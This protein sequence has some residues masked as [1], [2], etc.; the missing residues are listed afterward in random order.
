MDYRTILRRF[1][2]LIALVAVFAL[3]IAGQAAVA[4]PAEEAGLNPAGDAY[5]LNMDAQGRLYVS[6][7]G[8]GEIVRVDSQTAAYTV[9]EE[10]QA[11]S[12][13]RADAA[14]KVWWADGDEGRFGR[15]DPGTGQA[16]WWPAAG[17]SGLL[18]TQVD[19]AGDFWAVA[20][21]DPL[22]YRFQPGTSTLCTYTLPDG[23]EAD[24]PLAVD[25]AI[26]LG[27][28]ANERILRLNVTAATITT[29]QLPAGSSPANLALDA[30]GDLWFG[31]SNN[32]LLARLDPNADTLDTF[33]PPAGAEPYM[34]ALSENA[35]WYGEQQTG[36][37][38]RL[39]P[40][41]ATATTVSV[42]QSS[43]PVSVSC[44][45]VEAAATATVSTRSGTLAWAAKDYPLLADGEGWRI[46]GLPDGA[47][48]WGLAVDE[49]HIWYV[50]NGRLLLG[51]IPQ[52]TVTVRACKVEDADG[53][54]ATT[55]DQTPI[56]GWMMHL[57]V[58]GERQ[59]D[60]IRTGADGCVTWSDLA[61]GV[62]YGVEEEL[63][64]G[65]Q[66][67]TPLK[68]DFGTAAPGDSFLHTFINQKTV[69][70]VRACK[71]ED[72]D[73]DLA[74][75]G[76]QTP[77]ANWTIY[78]LVDGERQGTGSETGA[79]GCVSWTALV[80]GVRYGVEEELQSGWQALTP[81]KHDFGTAAPGDSLSHTFI[82][83][84][85]SVSPKYHVYLPVIVRP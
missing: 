21:G 72:A 38:G 53:D 47:L 39:W 54:L 24:Y 84:K 22:L 57:L 79:F 12:D 3:L 34:V 19:A 77:L 2:A 31:D 17:A 61:S 85:S 11:P 40:G 37:I 25:G 29:W 83:S 41:Q 6:D 75:T 49:E 5:E 42:N 44:E 23:G 78:L 4:E 68:H 81:L 20:F 16:T 30:A 82:N 74:T 62:R 36:S 18:G 50:D 73:G 76:D 43:A 55:G 67:L 59:G 8:A 66:A 60:G 64:S 45:S 70:A 15:L 28:Y 65:W 80:P 7:Y 1:A 35:L 46:Y 13:A 14:G 56:F 71:V 32:G 10:I 9:F 51:H 52:G 26:W 27:D 69:V 48:P 58:D 33:D 63:Q